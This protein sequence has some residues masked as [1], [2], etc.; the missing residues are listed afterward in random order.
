[1]DS[2]HCAVLTLMICSENRYQQVS[3]VN[4]IFGIYFDHCEILHKCKYKIMIL[5]NI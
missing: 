2:D 5:I 4:F 1:M 3:C